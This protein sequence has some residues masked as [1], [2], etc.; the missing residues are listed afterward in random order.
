MPKICSGF[1]NELFVFREQLH[2]LNRRAKV[3]PKLF[4]TSGHS[5]EDFL[6][7]TLVL[8][9]ATNEQVRW[10]HVCHLGSRDGLY[11][12]HDRKALNKIH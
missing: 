6:E 11:Q 9:K 4:H 3:G 10:D 5:S 7:Y 2:A 8:T 1:A 12:P